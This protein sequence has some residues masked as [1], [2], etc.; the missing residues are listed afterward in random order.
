VLTVDV[1]VQREL[2]PAASL[3][4]DLHLLE[5]ASQQPRR[6]WLRVYALAGEV[7]SLGRY[8]VAP[9]EDA[10]GPVRLHR[11]RGG[12]RVLALGPGIAVLSLTVPHRSALVGDDPLA[13]RPEQALNRWARALLAGLRGLGV[14]AFYPGRDRITVDRRLLGVV[15]LETDATGATVFEATLAIDGDQCRVAELVAAVDRE[16]VIAAE[17]LTAR[18]VTALAERGATP[19]LD[20]LARAVAGTLAQ[21]FGLAATAGVVPDLP[22]DAAAR[23]AAS[24]ASRRLRPGLDGHAVEWGQLGVFEVH[25]ATRGG[26]IDDLLLAGDYLAD[27]PSIARL[28]QGLRGC[29]LER[30]AIAAVVDAV[31]ADPRSFLLGVGSLQTVVDTIVRAA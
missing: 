28:E 14:D 4:L 15:S 1:L 7:V 21:Q 30:A 31:Y 13:L 16:R 24:I 6:A 12:G 3:A 18:Q 23:A 20:E 22:P 19:S 29:A 25:L 2:D 11:R 9:A 26:A 10:E 5:L 8:Q 27:S 17:V